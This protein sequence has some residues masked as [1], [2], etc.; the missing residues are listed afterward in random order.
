M[1]SGLLFGLLHAK[2]QAPVVDFSATPTSGCGP[3][4]VRFTD[5]STNTPTFWSWDFGNGQVSAKQNPNV[6]YTAP[7][8]YSVRLIARNASGADVAEKDGYIT[9]IP[10]PNPQ[11]AVNLNVA[12]APA[13]I[14]F[15]DKSTPG[16]GSITTWAWT[17][18]DGGSSTLQDPIH[19][20]S[21]TGY[22]NVGLKVTNSGGC[23]NTATVGRLV[24]VINGIQP[25][26]VYRQSST[27][28]NAPFTGELLN[29]TAG[30][31]NLTYNWTIGNGA[32]P[33]NSTDTNPIVTFP[34]L[35]QYNV[36]LQVTSSLGCTATIQEP[37]NLTN[38]GA[39]IS[40]PT[41]ACINTPV[42][43]ADTATPTPAAI[44]WTFSDGTTS[45]NN[46]VTKSFPTIGSYTVTLVNQ[47]GSCSASG[48]KTI[49]VIGPPTPDFTATSP[50]AVCKPPL[51]VQFSDQS[52]SVPAGNITGWLWDFGDGSPPD[53]LKNP[54]HTYTTSGNFNVSLTAHGPG[55]CSNTVTKQA[56][57]NI[58]A[59]AVSIQGILSG[60]TASTSSFNTINPQAN[61]NS[62]DGPQSYFWT[63]TGSNE[64][65]S[66]SPNPAFSYNNPGSYTLTV[67]VT[68]R[69]GCTASA[70][71]TVVVGTPIPGTPAFTVNPGSP[72]CSK[73]P[74]TFTATPSGASNYEWGFGDHSSVVESPTQ[75][76]IHHYNDY[77]AHTVTLNVYN[78]ACPQQVTQQIQV[79][80]PFAGFRFGSPKPVDCTTESLIQFTDTSQVGDATYGP[81][82]WSW[83]FGDGQTSTARN[84][85]HL[86]PAAGG[87]P[88]SYNAT[89]TI[90]QGGCSSPVTQTVTIGHVTPSFTMPAT[91][92]HK[93]TIELISTSTPASL[94]SAY[95]WQFDGGAFTTPRTSPVLDT[96]FKI[97]GTHNVTLIAYDLNNCPSTPVT[98]TIT[99][100]GPHA[101]YT[102]SAGACLNATVTFTDNSIPDSDPI[103]SYK[104]DW[105]DRSTVQKFATPGPFTHVFADTGRFEPLY[106]VTD[107]GNCSDSVG[108][109]IQITSPTANFAPP[110]SFY[111]PGAALTLIDSSQGY[112]LI[113]Q[114]TFGDGNSITSPAPPTNTYANKGTYQ[115]SLTVTDKYGCI[116][117]KTRSI[118]IQPP[119]AAF[120]IYDTT[121]ICFPL[122]TIFAAHGQYFDSLYWKF[123]D[124]ITST[125]DSTSHFYNAY[126]FDTAKL[127]LKGPG[128][129]LDSASYRVQINDP[130]KT[131]SLKYGPLSHCDLLPVQFNITNPPYSLF[132][133][134]FGDGSVD[135]SQNL[136]PFYTY[137]LPGTYLPQLAISDETGCIVNYGTGTTVTVLGAT[138]F[139]SVN[140]HA[141]CDSGIVNFTDYT[142]SNDGFA[143]ETYIFGDG[144]PDQSQTGGTGGFDVTNNYDKIG[145]WTAT[146]QV[147]TRDGCAESYSDTLHIYQTP[148]PVI[149]IPPIACAGVIQFQGSLNP[150]QT[151]SIAW[152]WKFGNGQS[153]NQQNPKVPFAPGSFRVKLNASIPFGCIDSTTSSITVNPSPDIKGPNELTVPLGIPVTIPFTYSADV[154]SYD[155]TP[156][157]NLSCSDCANPVATVT[158]PTT[159]VVTV[160]DANSCTASDTV[161]IKTVCN[162]KNYWFPN[163]FS[164]NGD[165]VNDYFYPRGTSLY[166]IQSLTIFNRWGQQV[167]QRMDFPANQ[168]SMG[169]DGTFGGKPAPADAYVYIAQVICE[170]AQVITISGNV[171]L[172]R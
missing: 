53:T 17:F 157:A 113:E 112:G 169:W 45:N 38:N 131:T 141:F 97:N 56:F 164:P 145:P 50:T 60:C 134:I 16:Q 123:G 142:I 104:W 117:T 120:N 83:D 78:G 146:L 85:Q 168:Q 115:A 77:G 73:T 166:N 30:P 18:G 1:I 100:T 94:D 151:D 152:S 130:A 129:C 4:T 24:R 84:P 2:A 127:Y 72:I 65:N 71:T 11:F 13:N 136:T 19:T 160:T 79:L 167:F 137:R 46:S 147:V 133:L 96:N 25:N 5:Q 47:Y 102:A 170:N 75:A 155:W 67:T 54:L 63:A 108:T 49:D 114:W 23:S 87:T 110:D 41:T 90:T 143:T 101:A 154:V 159:Y 69:G 124:G 35:G 10:Y 33:S 14:Q 6:T 126:G 150:P 86:Y 36:G 39:S 156:L 161:L 162:D 153:S 88:M 34:N 68:T 44:T 103:K 28:C 99:I 118:L 149:T 116:A 93:A 12:C 15:T 89:L 122:Q 80:P 22:Y 158:I 32:I 172:I 58:Q 52:T 171:T 61:L 125:L 57:V 111:C 55:G 132:N 40:G 165:G 82:T 20:Y 163:T 92:C 64:K 26:F 98:N 3:L 148:N 48:T 139:F 9:V 138:P 51:S 76:V 42:T 66:T 59:P 31:G 21:Q 140:K 128:G 62:V 107:A 29:Q 119:V 43:F 109:Y 121:A 144:S 91:G 37:V 74:I 106:V 105:D 8:T 7:G 135:S 70:S 27:S 81:I 95:S